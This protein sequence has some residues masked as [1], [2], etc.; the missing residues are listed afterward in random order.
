LAIT[1]FDLAV[2]GCNLW[3]QVQLQDGLG[4]IFVGWSGTGQASLNPLAPEFSFK[5]KHI[6]FLKFE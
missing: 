3:R 6:L 2:D 5:F 1:W 4:S